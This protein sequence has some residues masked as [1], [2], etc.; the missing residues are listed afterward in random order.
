MYGAPAT[1]DKPWFSF[2]FVEKSRIG[3]MAGGETS[4]FG[5]RHMQGY[6]IRLFRDRVQGYESTVASCSAR[7]GSLRSTRIPMASHSLST[8]LPTW[9]T[10]TIPI[11]FPASLSPLRRA[12]ATKEDNT[13][14]PT[15]AALQPGAF[16]HVIPAFSHNGYRYGRIRSWLS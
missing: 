15:E 14:C 12:T 16:F 10:P 8:I 4:L 7:G 11:V 1:V 9:P 3:E 13:Y 6:D 5:Q 2:Q